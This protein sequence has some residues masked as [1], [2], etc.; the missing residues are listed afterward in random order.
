M[1]DRTSFTE[2]HMS[3]SLTCIVRC[4]L[5]TDLSGTFWSKHS[6]AADVRPKHKDP[7]S[8]RGFGNAAVRSRCLA[9]HK[10]APTWHYPSIPTT[11]N[12]DEA[13]T[14]DLQW[15]TFLGQFGSDNHA[16]VTRRSAHFLLLER[17]RKFCHKRILELI[18]SIWSEFDPCRLVAMSELQHLPVSPQSGIG[19]Q[20]LC[21]LK[22]SAEGR[23]KHT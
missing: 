3:C 20:W 13:Q 9:Y 1:E 17:Y 12:D 7:A 23:T 19:A 8:H 6:G 15:I 18:H 21:P 5:S 10:A 11:T 2:A 16:P 4:E 22:A 14:Y